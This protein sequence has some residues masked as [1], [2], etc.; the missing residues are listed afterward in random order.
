MLKAESIMV[1]AIK[2]IDELFALEGI[3][4]DKVDT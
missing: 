3:W 2:S 1:R 4:T